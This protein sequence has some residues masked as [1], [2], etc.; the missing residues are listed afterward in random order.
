MASLEGLQID[1]GYEFI[2]DD[3][4]LA[5]PRDDG[6]PV[7]GQPW[8]KPGSPTDGM[9]RDR[10]RAVTTGTDGTGRD[11]PHPESGPFPLPGYPGTGGSRHGVALGSPQPGP[12]PLPPLGSPSATIGD[13]QSDDRGKNSPEVQGGTGPAQARPD[14]PPSALLVGTSEPPPKSPPAGTGPVRTTPPGSAEPSGKPGSSNNPASSSPAGSERRPDQQTSPAPVDGERPADQPASDASPAAGS[15]GS[16]QGS[17]LG[18]EPPSKSTSRVRLSPNRDWIIRVEC[19]GDGVVLSATG[20]HFPLIVLGPQ[21]DQPLVAAV[22]RMIERK[23]ATVR[24]GELEY[25]PQLRF[26]VHPDGFRS[27]YSAYPAL[28]LLRLP[29]SRELREEE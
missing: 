17:R 12:P 13:R 4:Q 6:D 25:H 27:Y 11:R 19:K 22:R 5:F 29:M 26:I 8:I 10:P 24:P 28:G 20:E 21:G 7:A 15:P 2:D 14:R 3:W 18:T 23:Q 16:G 1:F 9:I